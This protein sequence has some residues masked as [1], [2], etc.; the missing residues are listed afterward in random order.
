MCLN[1]L[2][3]WLSLILQDEYWS[4]DEDTYQGLVTR[5]RTKISKSTV[6]LQASALMFSHFDTDQN[7]PRN[8]DIP[9]FMLFLLLLCALFYVVCKLPG[10]SFNNSETK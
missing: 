5:R 4:A 6:Q 2:A 3:N 7:V 9:L 8:S 1:Q 10:N